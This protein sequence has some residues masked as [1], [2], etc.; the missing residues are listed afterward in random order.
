MPNGK[1]L[2]SLRVKK[3]MVVSQREER[4]GLK[5]RKVPAGD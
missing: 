5:K 3:K 2:S 1:S 4:K